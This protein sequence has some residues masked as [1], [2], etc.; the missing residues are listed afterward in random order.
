VIEG[1]LPAEEIDTSRP[2]PARI[3]D[4]L[5]GGWDNYEVDRETANRILS[6]FPTVRTS[7]RANRSFMER[8]MR[9]VATQGIRQVL[10][11]GCGIPTAPNVHEIA[12][13]IE[14][15]TR[16][17]YVDN[18][19]IVGVHARAR[20]ATTTGTAYVV[21]DLRHPRDIVDDPAVRALID[22]TQPVCVVMTAILNFVAD[23]ENP[24]GIVAEL[25]DAVPDGS[26]LV[27]SHATADFYGDLS[28]LVSA[29]NVNVTASVHLR[30]R[31]AITRYLDGFDLAE[32]GLVS[33]MRWRPEGPVR[34]VK[35][36]G[37]YGAVGI[38]R[39]APR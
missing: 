38:K 14:P 39:P 11:I 27:F 30:D 19:P 22:F 15:A 7:V 36:S 3:Y 13:T 16:V 26:H 31:D 5:L 29:Y 23:D 17:V 18:D 6:T 34:D 4:Y 37:Y 35:M 20:L 10:D 33:V 9:F 32:P 2:H 25:R 8:A 24:G 28:E 12:R 21:G 1:G